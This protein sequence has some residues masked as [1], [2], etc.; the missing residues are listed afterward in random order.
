MIPSLPLS[1]SIADSQRVV[2]TGL[3]VNTP[4]GDTLDGFIAGLLAGRSAIGH[5][6]GFDTASILVKIGGDLSGYD[7]KA[8]AVRLAARLPEPVARRLRKLVARGPWSAKLS[9]LLAADAWLDAHADVQPPD[10]GRVATIVAGHNINSL[11][12]H[13]TR[14][15][16]HEGPNRIDPLAALHTLDTNHAACIS[17]LLGLF[18]P[19]HT[20][21]GACASGNVAL[22]A[23]VDEI[24]H[25]GA[26]AALVVGA[27][28]DLSPVE[29]HSM[30]LMGA[31]S[32]TS[33]ND[34]PE[35]A[36]RPFEVR[37]EGFVPAHG[38][39]A[40]FV[41]SLASAR[42]RGVKIYAEVLGVASGSDANHF[43][44]P[45]EEKQ[46]ALISGLLHD[47]GV[48]PEEVDYVNAHATSTPLGDLA[49]IRALRRVFGAHAQ[50]LRINATKSML[51][52]TCWASAIV[53]TVAVA[54]QMQAGR[55]HPTIN[56]EALDP[57]IDLDV[58][59]N[60]AVAHAP[61]VVLKNAFGFGGINCI[62]L[63]RAPPA[64]T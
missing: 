9:L 59:A 7:L 60:S 54:L 48:A 39:G 41:E 35:R 23:A 29:L 45:N 46:A 11:W 32:C 52:H 64:G 49:E 58:C 37:R 33:F 28:L 1:S 53:E 21:G 42:A 56:L 57:E 6:R 25:H 10:L 24:R 8:K 16:F 63:L 31:V 17:E 19:I 26:A 36:S 2:I 14:A 3:A 43:T 5:W 34:E 38:G 22:R 20:A 61:R 30:A 44:N 50:R 13:G 15:A 51:G 18:G 47:C 12:D 4:L 40:L 62:S 27:V 55:L